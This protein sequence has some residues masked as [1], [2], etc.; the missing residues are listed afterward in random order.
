MYISNTLIIP[1]VKHK[2]YS[3]FGNIFS[4]LWGKAEESL[5]KANRIIIIGYS[6]PITDTQTDALFK[7]AFIKRSDM[8]EIIIVDPFPENILNRFIL[9]YG[10]H[11][12][13]IKTYKTYFNESFNTDLL[14]K[15]LE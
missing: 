13:K 12:D 9:D 10:I 6:F 14:F 1:P 15:A 8:P 7:S 2:N 4:Q 11:A 5:V 3:H